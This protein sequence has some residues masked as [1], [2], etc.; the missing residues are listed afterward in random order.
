MQHHNGLPNL[1]STRS[2]LRGG[3]EGAIASRSRIL[4]A[5]SLL[6]NRKVPTVTDRRHTPPTFVVGSN[7]YVSIQTYWWPNPDSPD[8]LP[9]VHRDGQPSPDIDKYD[10]PR[11]D[12]HA[13][14]VRA[15]TLAGVVTDDPVYTETAA[16]WIRTWFLH[17]ATRMA[18]H[19]RHAQFLPGINGGTLVGCIDLNGRLPQYLDNLDL[20]SE[21]VP[22][23]FSAAEATM[24]EEW[25]SHLLK[26]FD[27]TETRTWHDCR[28]NNLGVYY[29]LAV[30]N[31]A[32]RVAR[33]DL[34]QERL[35]HVALRRVAD[36]IEPDGA[37]PHE[38]K[39]ARSFDYTLMNLAGFLRLAAAG[40]RFGFDL[41]DERVD[42][43]SIRSAW[44]YVWSIARSRDDW[45]RPTLHP[46]NWQLLVKCWCLL[47]IGVRSDYSLEAVEHRIGNKVL[48][49]PSRSLL[50]PH[51]HPFFPAAWEVH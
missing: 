41:F 29:D 51:L 8:G 27:S 32:E 19:L 13:D 1:A 43:R 15:L 33:L 49:E 25:W 2:L 38:L 14:G 46:P 42:G 9:Y 22:D 36:Q 45:P 37:M 5:A 12:L 35:S 34:A 20:L 24:L 10:R 28:P 44:D 31:L 18:P 47:P 6:L 17:P 3:D 11:W 21:L 23:L 16:T 50:D 39:R 30:V 40:G 48:A 7:D 4:T 26:W